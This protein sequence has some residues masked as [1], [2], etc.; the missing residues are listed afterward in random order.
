MGLLLLLLR[1]LRSSVLPEEPVLSQESLGSVPIDQGVPPAPVVPEQPGTPPSPVVSCISA[2]MRY[3][4]I[5][6]GVDV[7]GGVVV[8][9]YPVDFGFAA[10]PFDCLPSSEAG[11]YPMWLS[12]VC[13][14]QVMAAALRLFTLLPG[15]EVI[16]FG[17]GRVGGCCVFILGIYLQ[18]EFVFCYPNWVR[19]ITKLYIG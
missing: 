11:G 14:G 17:V 7:A 2:G 18:Y 16:L 4:V 8:D 1:G 15:R 9:C 13:A 5:G 10:Y 3:W 12:Y 19:Y 6:V